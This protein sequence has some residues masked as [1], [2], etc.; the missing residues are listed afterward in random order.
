MDMVEE[1]AVLG[2]STEKAYDHFL[3]CGIR[4]IGAA[5]SPYTS[6][7]KIVEIIENYNP[8]HIVLRFPNAAILR[9]SIKNKVKIITLFADSLT[10]QG[11]RRKVKIWRLVR[12]L[13]NSGVEWVGNHHINSCASLNKAGVAPEK[14]VPWDWPRE[15]RTPQEF[16]PKTIDPNRKSYTFFY[17]GSISESKGVGDL[18]DALPLLRDRG[19]EGHLKI[20]GSPHKIAPFKE[21]AAANQVSDLVDFLGLIPNE[22]VVDSMR[23]V[24]IVFIP[25]RHCYAEG[26]PSTIYEALCSRTPIVASDHPM[27]LKNI[28]DGYSALIFPERQPE[29]IAQCTE[30]LLKN[31][32]LYLRL[33]KNSYEAWKNLQIPVTWAGFI[34]RWIADNPEENQWLRE[35]TLASD[36]YRD[37]I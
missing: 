10:S 32:E 3:D 5:T 22:K 31:P 34:R 21:Q 23:D 30:R 2:C 18:I 13:N 6:P 7:K 26:L 24:D 29:G 25:S 9:W 4:V 33:S 8:T 12:L 20:A 37:R 35:H 17:A 14:I 28:E 36:F 1:V 16:E 11:L 27:F 19:I 15:S